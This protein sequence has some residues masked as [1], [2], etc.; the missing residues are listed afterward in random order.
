LALISEICSKL[1]LKLVKIALR[2]YLKK[3]HN[4][5]TLVEAMRT[6]YGSNFVPIPFS[7]VEIAIDTSK[8]KEVAFT[9]VAIRATK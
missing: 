6:I 5:S 8:A 2:S 4:T 9:L 3:Y 1:F 7:D